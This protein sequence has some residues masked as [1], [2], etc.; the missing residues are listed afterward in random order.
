MSKLRERLADQEVSLEVG[1]DVKEFLAERGYDPAYGA[2]PLKRAIQKY[3]ETP[4]A[5]WLLTHEEREGVILVAS[6]SGD[7][8]VVDSRVSAEIPEVY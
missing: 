5:D 1:Q 6:M 3:L 4:L 8:I 7:R 2:R